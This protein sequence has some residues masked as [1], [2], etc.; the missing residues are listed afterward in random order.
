MKHA[1]KLAVAAVV[2]FYVAAYLW[3][4]SQHYLVHYS[5]AA[6]GDTDNHRIDTG[7]LGTGFN[8]DYHLANASYIVF[9]PLRWVETGYWYLRHPPGQPWPYFQGE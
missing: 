3:T 6:G 7:D 5:G 2:V 9:T 8:P 4:R 1:L